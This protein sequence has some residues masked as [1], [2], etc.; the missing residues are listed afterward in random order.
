[1]NAAI[2]TG[3][4]T[5]YAFGRDFRMLRLLGIG[6][7]NRAAR[8]PTRSWC[9]A[10]SRSRWCSRASFT[11]DGFT[12]MVAYTTP[13]FWT[14]FLAA[15]LAL[16]VFRSAR[17]A[18]NPRSTCRCIRWCRS[19]SAP[20]AATCSTRASTTCASP[21]ASARAVLAGIVVMALGIPLYFLARK[22]A[23]I[24]LTLTEL[25]Y[26]VAVAR[27]RH[28]GRAAEIL[29]R[30]AADAVGGDQEAR[31]GAGRGAVRA[32][33]RRG[34][35]DARRA[36]ASSS[37]RSACW[38]RPRASRT[39]RRPRPARRPVAAGRDLHH[40]P[41]SPAQA[42]SDP[43]AHRAGDAAPH[44]G[45]LYAPLAEALKQGE[46]DVIV[47]ALPFEEPGVETRAVYDEPFFVAVPKGHAWEGRKRVSS[48]E[49]TRESLLLL[50]RATASATRFSRSATPCA[51]GRGAP[52][53]A[54]SRAARSRPSARWWR[55]AWASPCCPPP[56]LAAPA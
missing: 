35:R 36:S 16:F 54:P 29:L 21:R 22:N 13:V 30:V 17:G 43:A 34:E 7:A 9:R 27:E 56:R 45:E 40:R 10:R 3:A 25:R 23:L 14:F 12:S 6:G 47:V 50:G 53:H 39:S 38:R 15:A 37:R 49:L 2:L 24:E 20:P 48:D 19:R 28:F 41:L 52:S 1:M 46:V 33:P 8:R 26:I 31:G 44:P 42:H 55:A 32:R 5:N 18:R 11:P 51:G 4:R